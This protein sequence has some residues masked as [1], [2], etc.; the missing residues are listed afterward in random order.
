MS[1]KRKIKLTRSLTKRWRPRSYQ[2]M[3]VTICLLKAYVALFLDPGLGKT[4]II[5]QV[6][7]KRKIRGQ[8]K[9]MLVVAPINP[10]YMTW[11]EEIQDWANFKRFTY[12]IMHGAKKDEAFN[13]PSDIYIINP[14]GLKWLTAKLKGMHRKN[15]PFD[16]LVVDESGKFKTSGTKATGSNRTYQMH[17]LVPGFKYRYILNGS[18]VAN[19]FLGLMSQM[20]IVDQGKSLGN[21]IGYYRAKYFEQKGKPEWK[22]F[23]LLNGSR[24][25]IMNKIAPVSICLRAEDHVDMPELIPKPVYIK[26]PPKA[27]KA[28]VEIEKE[29]F[30]IID[31]NELVAESAAS[32]SNKL[33][34]ICGGVL[35]EDQDPLAPLVPSAK[36]KTILLH[37]EKL[38]A[39][40][41]LIDEFNGK[42]ILVGYKFV[43]DKNALA[44]HYG[45]RIRFASDAKTREEKV[46]LQTDWNAG[47]IDI[48]AGNPKSIGHG[49]NLQKGDANVIVFY[50]INHD[51]DDHDQFIRRLRRSG[52]KS[53]KVFVCMIVA[54]D[55]YD[56]KVIMP[57][58]RGKEDGQD[59][60]FT[61]LKAYRNGRKPS[62]KAN[63]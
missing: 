2:A 38:L 61:A 53:S 16:M 50:N 14:E 45:K 49:L 20:F 3:C 59:W 4:S 42:Q 29:L 39:L 5:L 33:H 27:M 34:Q 60:F 55:L 13:T 18:P 52:N 11:P 25:R 41:D 56:H 1:L 63:K 31:D 26:L 30:T 22:M 58:L 37:K 24:K 19:G 28:Y 62:K 9:A 8:V 40:D 6:F 17:R 35:Y 47:K 43:H 46:K 54:K 36:R 21:K 10:C 57:N 23:V 32:L 12:T 44:K 48:L 51:Y 15:W 7:N